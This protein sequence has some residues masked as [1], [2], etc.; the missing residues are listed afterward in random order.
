MKNFDT[1]RNTPYYALLPNIIVGIYEVFDRGWSPEIMYLT[2]DLHILIK[3]ELQKDPINAD[4]H[5]PKQK[6]GKAIEA[7][8]HFNI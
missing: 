8:I 2:E 1:S 3:E 5:I 7:Q 6:N 4:I